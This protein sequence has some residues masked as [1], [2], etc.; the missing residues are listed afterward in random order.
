MTFQGVLIHMD[1]EK[2]KTYL[3]PAHRYEELKAIGCKVRLARKDEHG[4][5]RFHINE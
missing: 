1:D 5:W 3:L 4:V 2:P